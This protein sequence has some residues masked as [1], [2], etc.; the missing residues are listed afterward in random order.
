VRNSS[1]EEWLIIIS[2]TIAVD[3]FRSRAERRENCTTQ[4]F[5]RGL[6][7]ARTGRIMSKPVSIVPETRSSDNV[8]SAGSTPELQPALKNDAPVSLAIAT[9]QKSWAR[10]A[11]QALLHYGGSALVLFLLFKFLPGRHVWLALQALPAQL[12]VIGLCVYFC[13]HCIGVTKWRLMVNLA[14]AQLNVPQAARCYLAGL[15]GSLFLPSL[16][17]GDLVRATMALRLGR[18]KAG[19]LLASFLDRILDFTA[20]ALLAGIGAMLVPGALDRRSRA[21]FFMLAGAALIGFAILLALLTWFPA[22]WL[23]YRIRRKLVRLR[24]AAESMARQPGAVAGALSLAFAAQL[25]FIALSA[26]LAQACGLHLP[27]RDWLFVW[28]L[29]KMAAAIPIT[30]GGIGVREAALAALLLPFGAP[31]ALAVAAG[32]AWEAIVISGAL[33]AGALSLLLGRLAKRRLAA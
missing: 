24:L 18:S 23:S 6:W 2:V 8:A 3:D 13:G 20:L 16:I 19:V 32:L 1:N 29:A 25:V 5:E 31:A 12:W 17:G 26:Y 9:K 7:H 33:A 4:E 10:M 21:I 22:R 14:G 15:F 30:Q 11:A 27:F 28:P